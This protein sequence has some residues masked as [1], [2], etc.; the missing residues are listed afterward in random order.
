MNHSI[1]N[2]NVGQ[3]GCSLSNSFWELAIKEHCINAD[4]S[5]DSKRHS[6]EMKEKEN[7]SLFQQDKNDEIHPNS[8]FFDFDSHIINREICLGPLR[9]FYSPSNMLIG[10]EDSGNLFSSAFNSPNIEFFLDSIRKSQETFESFQGVLL[11]HS[12]SGGTGAGLT[13]FST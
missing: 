11:T 7:Q 10:H 6:E 12:I 5:L 1:L 8:L 2:I 3:T 9:D 13:S 4:G